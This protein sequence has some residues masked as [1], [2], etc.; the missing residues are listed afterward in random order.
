MVSN[1]DYSVVA[2]ADDSCCHNAKIL[3][4][5]DSLYRPVIYDFDS[6]GLVNASYAMANSSL[7]IKRV[8]QRL[9][10]GY[11]AHNSQ[12]SEARRQILSMREALL[13]ILRTDTV[14]RKRA[15]KQRVKYFTE[16]LEMIADDE[17]WQEK[18]LGACRG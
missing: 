16:S 11:C 18:V 17:V 8:T 6:S 3:R 13:D 9:Y 4:G 12:V 5:E 1:A 15:I 14:L 7:G 10:R 2:S